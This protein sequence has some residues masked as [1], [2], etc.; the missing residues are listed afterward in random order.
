[1]RPSATIA[2][3]GLTLVAR[4]P[5]VYASQPLSRT[6]TQDSL[7]GGGP[8]PYRSG[9]FTR[10]SLRE[11]S[12]RYGSSSSLRLLLAQRAEA[13]G[14]ARRRVME[15]SSAPR[16]VAMPTESPRFARA[17]VCAALASLKRCVGARR[18]AGSSLWLNRGADPPAT[19]A[20]ACAG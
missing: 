20:E 18:P 3:S 14:T 12:V 8:Q 4:A 6:T 2:L 16:T 15:S 7:P 17:T 10:G 11:V 1:C 5:A 9:T 19:Q 13:R